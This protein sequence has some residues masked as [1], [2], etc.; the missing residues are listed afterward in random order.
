MGASPSDREYEMSEDDYKIE[1]FVFPDGT[2][3]ELI[4]FEPDGSRGGAPSAALRTRED[5]PPVGPRTE[6]SGAAEGTLPAEAPE[7]IPADEAHICPCCASDLVYPVDCRRETPAT[8]ILDLRCPNCERTRRIKLGHAGVQKMSRRHSQEARAMAR[9]AETMKR[10]HF[11][12][13]AARI[14]EALTCGL[15]LPMDF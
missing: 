15:I 7:E 6:R 3:V 5:T 10:R 1:L 14:V 9:Q 12:E 4:V 2:T 13:E 11:E 8:W